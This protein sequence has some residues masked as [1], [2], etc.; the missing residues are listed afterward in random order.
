MS[1]SIFL[2]TDLVFNLLIASA[3]TTVMIGFFVWLWFALPL[4]YRSRS[5]RPQ[6]HNRVGR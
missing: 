5:G 6:S 3:V 2:I 1:G 4:L